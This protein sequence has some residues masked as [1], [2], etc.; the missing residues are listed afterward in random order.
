MSRI[1]CAV[2]FIGYSADVIV[3]KYARDVL[4]AI[5]DFV[6]SGLRQWGCIDFRRRRRLCDSAESR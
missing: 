5:V 3:R 1:K 2:K 4:Y 6:S